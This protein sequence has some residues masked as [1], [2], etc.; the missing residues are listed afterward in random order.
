MG[1]APSARRPHEKEHE[2]D[3]DVGAEGP[4]REGERGRLGAEAQREKEN[5]DD[6]Q[7]SPNLEKFSEAAGPAR[8]G[9]R[10]RLGRRAAS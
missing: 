8:E 6:P 9:A 10:G 2:D 7:S 4:A 5:E 1:G 3:W